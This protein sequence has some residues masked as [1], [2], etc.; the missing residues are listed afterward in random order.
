MTG[1]PKS[2]I[3]TTLPKAIIHP[4]KTSRKARLLMTEI[5]KNKK[6]KRSDNAS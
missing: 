5:I 1:K 3:I 4:M 2:G 6:N